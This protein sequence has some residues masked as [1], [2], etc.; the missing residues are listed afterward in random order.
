[1][2]LSRK[3]RIS[4]AENLVEDVGIGVVGFIGAAEFE[5]EF[6]GG[7]DLGYFAG[8]KDQPFIG[9]GHPDALVLGDGDHRLF[10]DDKPLVVEDNSPVGDADKTGAASLAIENG[11]DGFIGDQISADALVLFLVIDDGLGHGKLLLSVFDFGHLL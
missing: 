2:K 7:G 4:L 11:I 3:L 10:L 5:G 9:P 1:M 6:T 8:L